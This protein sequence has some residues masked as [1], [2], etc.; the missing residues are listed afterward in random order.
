[1]INNHGSYVEVAKALNKNVQTIKRVVKSLELNYDYRKLNR[2]LDSNYFSVIDCEEKAWLLGLLF[3][4]GSVRKIGN[5]TGQIRLSLQLQDEP[6]INMIK[7]ILHLDCKT[8]YDKREGKEAVG[9]EFVNEQIFNDLKNFGIVPNKTYYTKGLYLDK[10]PEELQ[11]HYLRGLFD[12][13][14]GLTF[15]GNIYEISVDFTSYFKETVEDFQK[16]IDIKLD[17]KEH[18]IIQVSENKSRCAWRGRQQCLK[19]LSYLYEDASFYL[20]RKYD[21]YLRIKATV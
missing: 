2:E 18:N 15:S 5:K 4:D 21:K 17:K 14:G 3:T 12:G 10:I 6:T 16:A 13:D 8:Q 20:K 9:F 7:E 1:M 19:I 11:R